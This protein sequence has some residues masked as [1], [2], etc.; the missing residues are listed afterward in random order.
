MRKRKLEFKMR[1]GNV[2]L[3]QVIDKVAAMRPQTMKDAN[4]NSQSK[5]SEGE[6]QKNGGKVIK[7]YGESA[8]HC[9]WSL[10]AVRESQ[11]RIQGGR[12]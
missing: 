1:Q 4:R 3:R 5:K 8:G 7:G 11:S 6:I 2:A 9:A 12:S 10:R